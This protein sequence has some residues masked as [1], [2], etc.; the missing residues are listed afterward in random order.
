MK[1]SLLL[2]MILA[3]AVAGCVERTG[4]NTPVTARLGDSAYVLSDLQLYQSSQDG[5]RP[6]I[7]ALGYLENRDSTHT[8]YGGAMTINGVTIPARIYGGAT[9]YLGRGDSGTAP[10]VLDGSWHRFTI[11]GAAGYPAF[12][13]SLRAPV[14]ATHLSSPASH[15]TISRQAGFT[16]RWSAN[17]AGGVNIMLMDTSE[18]IGHKFIDTTFADDP[19]GFTFT[20][21]QLSVLDDGPIM[22]VVTRG[23]L[24]Y[25][26]AG[27]HARYRIGVGSA[28]TVSLVLKR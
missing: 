1:T 13:D 3:A 19:G 24:K 17:S 27:P 7:K 15:D 4:V 22:L 2:P 12:T 8:V 20:T 10:L 28:E 25:G 6:V 9:V 16:A 14:G 21:E 18:E 26:I 11:A 23:S 5:S